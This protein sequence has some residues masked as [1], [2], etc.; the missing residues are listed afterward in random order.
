MH[1][2]PD[3]MHPC[4]GEL[5]GCPPEGLREG[6]ALHGSGSRTRG[7]H[8]QQLRCGL[9]TQS[10]RASGQEGRWWAARGPC[11]SLP[12][13][14]PAKQEQGR[15]NRSSANRER[16]TRAVSSGRGEL[17]TARLCWRGPR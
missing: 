13:R 2:V 3:F 5:V 8:S 7:Q 4:L 11:P 16:T 9:E 14:A 12:L 10:P 17:G 1:N 6:T 15:Q